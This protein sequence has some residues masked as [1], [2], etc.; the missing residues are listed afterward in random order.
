[1]NERSFPRVDK[2]ECHGQKFDLS[3]L[4]LARLSDLGER[5]HVDLQSD[6]NVTA[7]SWV[8]IER[9]PRLIAANDNTD[10]W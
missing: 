8:N 5:V 9:R 3:I 2:I 1:M 4:A 10:P 6:F 7:L